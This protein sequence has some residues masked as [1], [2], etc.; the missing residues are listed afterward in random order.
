M[1]FTG[2]FICFLSF[3]FFFFNDPATT[4]IYTLSLHDALPICSDPRVALYW[5]N[6][7][8]VLEDQGRHAEAIAA[9]DRALAS[10][11]AGTATCR[12]DAHW[13]LARL[14]EHVGRRTAD[15]ELMRTAVR[16]LLAY[17]SSMRRLG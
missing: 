5:F 16:H 2:V 12:A 7:G 14:C 17:R 11:V 3:F 15:D 6:L 8:V 10:A 1:S 9:Y 13:N 4:E